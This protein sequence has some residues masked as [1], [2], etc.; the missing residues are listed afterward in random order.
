VFFASNKLYVTS[1]VISFS[2][3]L[4]R[5]KEDDSP[6]D[7]SL[8]Q[9]DGT[10]STVGIDAPVFEG[11]IFR[12]DYPRTTLVLQKKGEFYVIKNTP[13]VFDKAQ[14][15]IIGYLIKEVNGGKYTLIEQSHPLA[16]LYSKRYGL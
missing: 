10:F 9:Q 11:A 3:I 1:P 5:L 15:K 14:M 7:V 12:V 2:L 6:L 13:L 16:P 8:Q 4:D